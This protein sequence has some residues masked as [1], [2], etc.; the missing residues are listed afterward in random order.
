MKIPLLRGV[1]IRFGGMKSLRS[2]RALIELI[3]QL[4]GALKT[5]IFTRSCN[6]GTFK[7]LIYLTLGLLRLVKIVRHAVIILILK[8]MAFEPGAPASHTYRKT[9]QMPA[10][11]IR[12]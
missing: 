10:V 5:Q 4:L 8:R 9:H 2:A 3:V 1:R 6:S 7:V 12:Q 11:S